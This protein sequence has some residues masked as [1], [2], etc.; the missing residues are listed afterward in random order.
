MKFFKY[1]FGKILKNKRIIHNYKRIPVPLRD[2]VVNGEY[3]QETPYPLEK[4]IQEF[5]SE[6]FVTK[7]TKIVVMGSCFAQEINK[8]LRENGFAC[9]QHE[10]GVVYTPQSIAQIIQYSFER[11]TWQPI[12]PFWIIDGK[13]LSP[14]LKADNHKGPKYLGEDETSA[15]ETLECHYEQSA[16]LLKEAELVFWNIGLTEL[17]R[18]KHD[19]RAFY[20]FPYP[21]V[22]DEDKHEFYNLSYQDVIENLKYAVITLKKFNP[23]VKIIF[24]I[25]PV[26]LSVSF[27]PNIGPYLATQYS[28][29][30]LMAAAMALVEKYEDVLYMPSYEI[31][32]NNHQS[33]YL[34]DGRHIN[35]EGLGDIMEA[36]SE[37][38]VID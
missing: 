33:Y 12:E 23:N 26:P 25:E 7:N 34:S 18:N 28:K 21:E 17:W 6:S 27:R 14:Y 37:L 16:K 8:W 10:W 32:R 1:L 9:Q 19:H 2:A 35:T 20:A 29:S 36:F 15:Q 31:I 13:Y 4:I 3:F 24:S 22:Y 38:Y 5:Q 11:S 30:V